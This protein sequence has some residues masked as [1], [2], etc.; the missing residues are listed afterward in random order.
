MPTL[1]PSW[2]VRAGCTPVVPVPRLV[3]F[4]RALRAREPAVDLQVSH[5]VTYDQL[6]LLLAGDLDLAIVVDPDEHPELVF[7]PLFAGEA[8][9]AC[10][11]ADH[12]L[13][14][15]DVVRPGDLQ[16]E[17]IVTW[18]RSANPPAYDRALARFEDAGYRF[19]QVVETE[20]ATFRELVFAA[21]S[22]RGV[23][24][25]PGSLEEVGEARLDV[26]V[27]PLEPV[28]QLSA[29]VLAW[30]ANGSPGLI[31]ILGSVRDVARELFQSDH[32][33]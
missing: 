1:A 18:P 15:K 11:S 17:T 12:P 9:A 30:R 8:L 26:V 16:A 22:G 20:G 32:A 24:F 29:N 25:V 28:V 23:S 13:A 31:P 14:A 27:R 21:A 3:D 6:D 19:A 4:V 7:Q 2:I 5:Q 33:R 10:V